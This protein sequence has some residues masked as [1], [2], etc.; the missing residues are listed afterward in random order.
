MPAHLSDLELDGI[1]KRINTDAK[2]SIDKSLSS[3][4]ISQ[5]TLRNG[6]NESHL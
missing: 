5:P 4:E 2:G 6:M 3:V 1:K